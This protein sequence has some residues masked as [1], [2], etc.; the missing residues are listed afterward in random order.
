MSKSD[1]YQHR[2]IEISIEPHKL[3][4]FSNEAGISQHMADMIFD[5]EIISL[6]QKLLE[7]IYGIING[8]NLTAHQKKVLTMTLGGA[9]Q[10]EI[11]DV[12]GVTQ[13]AI[14]KALHGNIDY[15]NN[16]KRYGGVIKKLQKLSKVNPYIKELLDKIEKYKA[17]KRD[18]DE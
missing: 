13:S 6:R 16:K 4:N 15:R 10:N 18:E 9:T 3:S 7:E 12:I 11:A 5:E 17:I 2:I 14:H 8:G 1:H